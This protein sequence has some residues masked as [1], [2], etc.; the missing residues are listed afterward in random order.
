MNLVEKLLKLDGGKL[1]KPTEEVK[2]ERLCKLLGE[3][4][5]FTCTAIS[6]EDFNKIQDNAVEIDKKGRIVGFNAGEM[7]LET[8][9]AGVPEL[10]SK[11]LMNHFGAPTPFEL[12]KKLLLPGE[13]DKLNDAINRLSGFKDEE[14]IKNEIK[15]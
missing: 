7:K 15:N 8:I 11:E 3:D 5:T 10:K 1:E 14:D 2:I 12:I 4:V 6:L 9:L 13:L